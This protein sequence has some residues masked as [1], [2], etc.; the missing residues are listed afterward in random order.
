MFISCRPF[1][2]NPYSSSFNEFRVSERRHPAS[3][4]STCISQMPWPWKLRG[5]RFGFTVYSRSQ[6]VGNPIASTLKSNV[7]GIP[8]LFGLNQVSNFMGFTVGRFGLVAYCGTCCKGSP[9]LLR[10]LV[11]CLGWLYWGP[12]GFQGLGSVS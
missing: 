5:E 10:F 12:L 3:K 7:E 1:K 2:G 6:K 11:Y 4:H 9:Y 8:A